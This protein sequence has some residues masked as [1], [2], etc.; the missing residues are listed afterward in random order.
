VTDR[1]AHLRSELGVAAAMVVLSIV[2]SGC[3]MQA[4]AGRPAAAAPRSPHAVPLAVVA[5]P[6]PR[7]R[8]LRYDTSGT[9]PQVRGG[10]V[11]LRAVNNARREGVLADQREYAPAARKASIRNAKWYRGV[12]QTSVD[13]RLLSASTVVVSA[14]LPATKLYPG[15]NNGR[16]WVAVTVRVPSGAP[17]GISDLFV[18]PAR[19]LPLL[20]KAFKAQVRRT[21]PRMWRPCVT[22]YPSVYLPTARNFRHFALTPRGLALGFWQVPACNRLQATVPYSIVQPYLSKLGAALIAGV[23]APR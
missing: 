18:E 17:V 11:D 21:E 13:R 14:L 7:V 6:T 12:Y 23:R 16:T 8:L 15:G 19:A 4:K 10:T 5:A 20:A 1:A 2:V 22:Y 3:G 9:Y